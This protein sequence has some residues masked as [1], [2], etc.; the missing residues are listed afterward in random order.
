MRQHISSS[1][2]INRGSRLNSGQQTNIA[3]RYHYK[4]SGMNNQLILTFED[5]KKINLFRKFIKSIGGI[6]VHTP[7]TKVAK[8]SDRVKA[9]LLQKLEQLKTLPA[10]WNE[11]G[12]LPIE[13]LSYV[14]AKR[15]I[16]SAPDVMLEKWNLFPDVNGTLLLSP[17]E[18]NIGG[19]SIG[20]TDFSYAAYVSNDKQISGKEP[21]SEESFLMALRQ[22]HRFFGYA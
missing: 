13:P 20:N 11:K 5:P 3:N 7:R 18:G 6:S 1:A 22:I 16:M 15:A 21:F 14:N 8:E 17:K 2:W 9:E 19:I 12:D 10:D 4:S